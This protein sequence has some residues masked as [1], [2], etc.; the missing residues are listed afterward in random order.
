LLPLA[1]TWVTGAAESSTL[2]LK[3]VVGA[4]VL[5]RLSLYVSVICAPSLL[6]AALR[7]V[8]AVVSG[9]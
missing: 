6:V 1:T 3:A 8:G 7:K 4:V 9:I 2:T 5:L